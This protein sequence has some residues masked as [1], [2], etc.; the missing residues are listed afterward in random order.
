MPATGSEAGALERALGKL[1]RLQDAAFALARTAAAALMALMLYE[2]VMRYVFGAPSI[3][4]FELVA[5]LNGAV[6]VLAAGHALK[7]GGHVAVDAFV[8]LY[9][10]RAHR[11]VLGLFYLAILGP[12][13]GYVAEA[14]M[15]RALVAFARGEVDDVSPWRHVVWPQ[16]ALLT[17]GFGLFALAAAVRGLRLLA[18]RRADG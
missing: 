5:L 15:A 12:L 18:G 17:A 14:G 4:S 6:F 13:L 10:P 3:W 7:T 8:R 11:I 1:D 9:P 16:Y 2:V